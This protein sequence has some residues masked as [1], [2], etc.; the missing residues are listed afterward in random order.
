MMCMKYVFLADLS[1]HCANLRRS[2]QLGGN[3]G[4]GAGIDAGIAVS[5]ADEIARS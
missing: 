4:P 3:A 2:C 1:Q 5:G